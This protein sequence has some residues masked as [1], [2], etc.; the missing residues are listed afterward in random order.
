[1][2]AGFRQ[3]ACG[4]DLGILRV[5]CPRPGPGPRS[6]TSLRSALSRGGELSARWLAG[7]HRVLWPMGTGSG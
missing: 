4:P 3:G 5:T 6:P 1:M 7:P 2:L